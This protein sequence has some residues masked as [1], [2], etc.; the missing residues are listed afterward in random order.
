MVAGAYGD[1]VAMTVAEA[2]RQILVA[3]GRQ[4]DTVAAREVQAILE[5]LDEYSDD[6]P[7][8]EIVVIAPDDGKGVPW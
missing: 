8:E 3:V 6:D 2:L 4:G 1:L 7:D 5:R